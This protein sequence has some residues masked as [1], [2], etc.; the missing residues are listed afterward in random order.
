MSGKII[1]FRRYGNL[2]KHRRGA[3]TPLRRR[4]RLNEQIAKI[5]ARLEEFEEINRGATE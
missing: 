2:G 3:R 4:P 5:E 1:E